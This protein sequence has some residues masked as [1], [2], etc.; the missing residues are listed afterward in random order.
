MRSRRA[1]L[2]G[3]VL[4]EALFPHFCKGEL[5]ILHPPSLAKAYPNGIRS[6]KWEYYGADYANGTVVVID[7]AGLLCAVTHKTKAS[8]ERMR[9]LVEGKVVL[10][11]RDT[12]MKC[13]VEFSYPFLNK[14]GALAF[15]F[16]AQYTTPGMFPYRHHSWNPTK[17]KSRPMVMEDTTMQDFLN[18]VKG[19]AKNLPAE[20]CIYGKHCAP[21]DW[22]NRPANNDGWTICETQ[23]LPLWKS[24][25]LTTNV[26]I[27]VRAPRVTKYT[28]VID[29]WVHVLMVRT[30][31]ALI[32]FYTMGI[33]IVTFRN[34]YRKQA[35]RR[36]E[37]ERRMLRGERSAL[38]NKERFEREKGH[39][40]V[41]CLMAFI[42]GGMSLILGVYFAAG[43]HGHSLFPIYIQICGLGVF[44]QMGN[45]TSLILALHM[46]ETFEALQRRNKRPH[47]VWVKHSCLLRCYLAIALFLDAAL[48]LILFLDFDSRK[49]FGYHPNLCVQIIYVASMI[50]YSTIAVFFLTVSWRLGAPL[51]KHLQHPDSNYTGS[52][53]SPRSRLVT[54]LVMCLVMS[55]VC[56]MT[57]LFC[58]AIA[59]IWMKHARNNKTDIPPWGI[60]VI[61][62]FYGWS[63]IGASHF[64]VQSFIPP[65]E[66][67]RSWVALLLSTPRLDW[68]GCGWS[69]KITPAAGD[70]GNHDKEVT[71]IEH[72]SDDYMLE[73]A[74]Y[75]VRPARS[76]RRDRPRSRSSSKSR[77]S[78]SA[79][80][81][82]IDEAGEEQERGPPRQSTI[83]SLTELQQDTKTADVSKTPPESN[84]KTTPES[85]THS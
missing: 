4:L 46:R 1:S 32:C 61:A 23:V 56:M 38:A 48:P 53:Q 59:A 72:E 7:D 28:E 78:K 40:S 67:A 73:G 57:T 81:P 60:S 69:P 66:D 13:P 50:G 75:E 63:R 10:A 15:I 77:S 49:D 9:S 70:G 14:L 74:R 21:E 58:L 39:W 35:M 80:L 41:G 76:G 29:S 44:S 84:N 71:K 33:A 12:A 16:I 82:S 27:E 5:R 47:N 8:R 36:G 24:L 31:P 62:S 25:S 18:S 34:S 20:Q 85:R 52:T 3:L 65:R 30:I 54:K 22:M 42:E 43:V 26:V 55:L 83:S 11:Q 6:A 68:P 37:E 19:C 45:V 64:Q 17:W 79:P 51:L 2:L